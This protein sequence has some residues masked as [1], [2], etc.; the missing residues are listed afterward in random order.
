MFNALRE[1]V[2]GMKNYKFTSKSQTEALIKYNP[3]NP[4][5]GSATVQVRVSQS[6]GMTKEGKQLT[7]TELVYTDVTPLMS[8]DTS[9]GGGDIINQL[10]SS[11]NEYAQFKGMSCTTVKRY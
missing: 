3:S 10:K 9:F 8:Q 6:A 11:F 1:V 2:A 7:G 4:M 5:M